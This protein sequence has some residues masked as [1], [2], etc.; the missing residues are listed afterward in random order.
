MSTQVDEGNYYENVE[1]WNPGPAELEPMTGEYAS[2]EAEVTF[3]VALEKDHLV[4][5]RRPDATIA[6]TP[7][8]RDG[9]S[10]SL[11]SIRFLRDAQGNVSEL[12]VGEQRVWDMRFRRVR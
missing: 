9:F 4:I 11:G 5:H 6:L 3:R 10:S 12:S 7:T 8:Y 1:R 2:D